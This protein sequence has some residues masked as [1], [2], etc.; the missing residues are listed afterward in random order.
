MKNDKKKYK[1]GFKT[2]DSYFEEL[3]DK[4]LSIVSEEKLPKETGYKVPVDYFETIEEKILSK[5]LKEKETK[6]VSIFSQKNIWYVSGI[7]AAIL[8]LLFLTLNNDSID[9]NTINFA[10]IETY[11]NSD[12]LD[13][14][15]QDIAQLLN[16]EDL[17]SLETEILS[18]TKESIENYLLE[19][20]DDTSLLIE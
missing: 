1:S 19:S 9:P 10:E 6:V 11:I 18:I 7:A 15:A 4:L 16:E 8:L 3:G 2:P 12:H 13:L 20:L 5:T 14:E 17:E